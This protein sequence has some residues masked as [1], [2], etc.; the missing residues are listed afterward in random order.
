MSA[1]SATESAS[2]GLEPGD[3]ITPELTAMRLLGGGAAYEAWL[4]ADDITY[5][6]TVVK[7][8]RPDQVDDESTL[9]GLRR[10]IDCLSTVNHPSVVRM[11]RA[12][13]DGDRPLVLLEHLDG[14]RLSSLVRRYGPLQPQQYLPL[15][16][17]VASAIHYFDHLELVHLDIKPSNI[18][19]GAPAKLIDLSIMRPATDAADLTSPVGTDAWMSPEQADPGG[20][21]GVPTRASDVWGLGASLHFALTGEKPFGEGD[22]DAPELADQFPQLTEST[23]DLPEGTPEPV[24]EVVYASLD[25]DPAS[26][27]LPAEVVDRLEPVL[28]AQPRGE[29][30]GKLRS[31]LRR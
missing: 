18:I 6:A 31:A 22:P 2:W 11:L 27:P 3:A 7:V 30:T 14:P 17:E 10:E 8:V 29:L 19:M 9:R 25:P 5:A 26:R 12:E 20:R 28:A 24:A 13:P 15:A 23:P 4:A 21:Y 16:I 1:E